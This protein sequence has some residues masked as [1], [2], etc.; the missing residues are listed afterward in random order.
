MSACKAETIVAGLRADDRAPS[1]RR[2]SGERLRDGLR[3]VI[4]GPP[5]A[6]KSSLLNALAR[7]D[8]AIVSAEAGTTRDVIEVHLDLGGM[9]VMLIDTAGLREARRRGR[10]EGI[11]AGAG[12]GRRTPIW[13]C[14]WSMPPRRNGTRLPS[15]LPANPRKRSAKPA[16]IAVLNKI[17][18]APDAGAGRDGRRSLGQDRRR[19]SATLVAALAEHAALAAET[20]AGAPLPDPGPRIR[21]LS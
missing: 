14:G 15:Y 4:A 6:G 7:R 19:A 10:G 13:C 1:R 18:L 2:G 5:N 3:V 12:A 9:P 17:D 16:L 20:A 21:A 8:V 11:R